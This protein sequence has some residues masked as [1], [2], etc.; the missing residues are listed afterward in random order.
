MGVWLFDALRQSVDVG[1]VLIK[2]LLGPG[3]RKS[4]NVIFVAMLEKVID[5]FNRAE[6]LVRQ[7][8][9]IRLV[10]SGFRTVAIGDQRRALV[11]GS[12]ASD[13]RRGVAR[14]TLHGA[15]PMRAMSASTSSK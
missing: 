13:G 14:D 7:G 8:R 2:K 3:E 12:I 11:V 1:T 4:F 6:Q 10:C 15:K 9:F 5:D